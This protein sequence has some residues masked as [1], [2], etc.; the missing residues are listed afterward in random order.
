MDKTSRGFQYV[1]NNF[2]DVSDAKI[3]DGIFIG[4][5]VRE[6]MQDKYFAEDLNETE[7]NAWLSFE[8]IYKNFLGN[9]KAANYQDV[10]QDML[11]SYKELWNS[12]WV[13]KST[14]WSH[15][16]IFP[17]KSRQS[18]WRTRWK[19]SPRHHGYRK[20]VPREV[21]LKY[22]GRLLL[23]AEEGCTWRQIPAKVIP[24]TF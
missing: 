15:T 13:W 12:V 14:F 9:H 24:S 7:R 8:R 17:R 10:V 20:A 3:N 5:Q 23:D 16:W 11:T 6:L 18:Q 21:D 22:V 19:F 1:R 2:P 4:T